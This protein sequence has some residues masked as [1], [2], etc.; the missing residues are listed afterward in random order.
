VATWAF[1]NNMPAGRFTD[2]LPSSQGYYFPMGTPRGMIGV[3]GLYINK[4]LSLDQEA[5]LNNFIAQIASSYEREQSEEYARN[6]LIAT[7]SEKLYK[8]FINSVS[9]EFRTPISIIH[10]ASSGLLDDNT[11][12]E[13]NAVRDLGGEILSA[14]KRMDRLV[15]NLLNTTRLESG[16]VHLKLDW[17]DI[18]DVISSVV[19]HLEQELKN[20]RV[21]LEME[22]DLPLIRADYV[23]LSQAITN[24]L[25]NAAAYTPS[26]SEIIIKVVKNKGTINIII[27]DN[28]KGIPETE[29]ETIFEKFYRLPGTKAGGT[30][31]GLSISR[32][33]VEAHGGRVKAE[34]STM[35]G[36]RFVISLPLIVSS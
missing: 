21:K 25:Q 22:N 28:G 6:M 10:A 26:G 12:K 35:G 16:S 34:N 19:S 3:I 31:L 2:N 17:H 14:S 27:E 20:H 8:T 18:N 30:G 23:L 33:F 24:I 13:P 36:A 9:H 15:E 32:G 7:E 29:L 4:R 1:E 5:M 11:I